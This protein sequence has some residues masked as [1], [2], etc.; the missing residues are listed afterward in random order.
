MEDQ[1]IP[2]SA[3]VPVTSEFRRHRR[4]DKSMKDLERKAVTGDHE[5]A[6]TMEGSHE[7]KKVRSY[8]CLLLQ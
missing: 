4:Y 7:F 5:F 6:K 8:R 1:L 2:G 3:E